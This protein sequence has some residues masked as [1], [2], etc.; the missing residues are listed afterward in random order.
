MDDNEK[1]TYKTY[2]GHPA[3]AL[4]GIKYM[5]LKAYVKKMDNNY[6]SIYL[7]KLVKEQRVK[8][9]KTQKEQN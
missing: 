3:E 9:E 1:R 2:E 7:K 8:H 4:L 6:L 5:T